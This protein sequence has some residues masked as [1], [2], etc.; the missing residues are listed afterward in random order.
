[1]TKT[2]ESMNKFFI[3]LID[4]NRSNR[5]NK[6]DKLKPID[7]DRIEQIKI[8]QCDRDRSNANN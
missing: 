5:L 4:L 3:E 7:V 2:T 8:E 1:L 6:I